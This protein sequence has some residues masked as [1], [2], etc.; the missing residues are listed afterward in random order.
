MRL[1]YRKV[2]SKVRFCGSFVVFR[3]QIASISFGCNSDHRFSQI[4]FFEVVKSIHDRFWRS[5]SWS[6]R[7]KQRLNF[8]LQRVIFRHFGPWKDGLFSQCVGITAQFNRL[9]CRQFIDSFS[10]ITGQ[11]KPVEVSV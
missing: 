8:G 10:I 5:G 6:Y 1:W 4:I 9:G 2:F 7:L 11:F 3:W